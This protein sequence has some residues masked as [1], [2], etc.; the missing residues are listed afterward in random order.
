MISSLSNS[1]PLHVCAHQRDPRKSTSASIRVVYWLNGEPHNVTDSTLTR[2]LL[3]LKLS[4]GH[5]TTGFEQMF[6]ALINV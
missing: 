5:Y 1:R 2:R 4:N 3:V 6:F